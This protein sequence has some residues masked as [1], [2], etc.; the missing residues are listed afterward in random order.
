M[1]Q[2]PNAAVERLETCSLSAVSRVASMLDVGLDGVGPGAP[3]P[4]GWHFILLGADTTRSQLRA[5]GFPGLGVS[6]PDLG[7][8]RVLQT[9]R[10]ITFHGEIPVGAEVARRSTIEGVERKTTRSGDV[11]FVT[12]RHELKPV[13]GVVALSETQ[14][15]VLMPATTYQE[16]GKEPAAPVT[17]NAP[18]VIKPDDTL[19][20]QYSAL[21]F[22][23]HKIH[24]DREYARSVEGFPE[25]VVN[26]GL[27]ALMLTEYLRIDLGIAPSGIKIRYLAPLFSNRALTIA[28]EER[29]E[30]LV[31]KVFNDQGKVAGEME[32]TR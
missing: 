24:L 32:V 30:Q 29:A 5:D 26:G 12:T 27:I 2:D 1:R 18:K 15:F 10:E 6:L 19:L 9:G 11:A 8:P 17:L 3:L 14:T 28:H 23:S 13:N 20:F 16:P 7:L 25:L 4:L 21:G 31:I 22:N